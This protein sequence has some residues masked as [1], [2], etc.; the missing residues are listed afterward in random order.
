MRTLEFQRSADHAD[1]AEI[2]NLRETACIFE[3]QLREHTQIGVELRRD[4]YG[5]RG[6]VTDQMKAIEV[7][8]ATLEAQIDGKLGHLNNHV[9]SMIISWAPRFSDPW[10][11]TL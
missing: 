5:I 9:A 11:A 4:V 6:T 3:R 1:H 7:K 8:F 10:T 2:A